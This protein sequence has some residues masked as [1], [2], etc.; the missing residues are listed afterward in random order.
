[1]MCSRGTRIRRVS[2]GTWLTQ[3]WKQLQ[4]PQAYLQQTYLRTRWG[5]LA[6]RGFARMIM[7]NQCHLRWRRSLVAGRVT[8]PWDIFGHLQRLQRGTP[9]RCGTPRAL[10]AR[11]AM[12]WFNFCIRQ[13]QIFTVL[14]R[15]GTLYFRTQSADRIVLCW[16][17]EFP[18]YPNAVKSIE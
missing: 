10:F 7:E 18:I 6:L 2:Q 14:W 8:A 12:G 15:W 9:S 4:W 13:I 5:A 1:M 17:M 3:L 11:E 16:K